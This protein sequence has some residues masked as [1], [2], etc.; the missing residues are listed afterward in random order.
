MIEVPQ[1]GPMTRR[2]LAFAASFS[3]TSSSRD[4]LLLKRKTSRPLSRAFIASLFAN[5]PGMDIRARFASGITLTAEASVLGRISSASMDALDE[6]ISSTLETDDW[7][8]SPLAASIAI[9]RSS[10]PAFSTSLP[11]NPAS[12]MNLLLSGV[13]INTAACDTPFNFE[14]SFETFMS[15]TESL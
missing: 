12:V 10:G 5:L 4:T 7:R 1:S 11:S 8:T 15:V 2:L 13:A 3:S 14:T 6:S 9:I